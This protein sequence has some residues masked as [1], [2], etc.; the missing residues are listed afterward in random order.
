MR[1]KAMQSNIYQTAKWCNEFMAKER[2]DVAICSSSKKFL[3]SG[4][5]LE[6][7]NTSWDISVSGVGSIYDNTSERVLSS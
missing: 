7:N 5:F 4:N 1:S 3:E 2:V 6:I